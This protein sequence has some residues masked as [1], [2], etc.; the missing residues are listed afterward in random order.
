[1][2][3]ADEVDPV[4]P[5]VLVGFDERGGCG[6]ELGAEGFVGGGELGVEGGEAGAG[7]DGDFAGGLGACAVEGLGGG[8][9]SEREQKEHSGRA[10]HGG[11]RTPTKSGFPPGMTEKKGKDE[12]G[13]TVE[14]GL[15]FVG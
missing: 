5:F 4:Q 1:V 14:K 8:G 3:R 7:T 2:F 13:F 9:E 6:G 12:S 15:G 10:A 11:H